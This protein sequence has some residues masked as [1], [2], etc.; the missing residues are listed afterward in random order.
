MNSG[1]TEHEQKKLLQEL[2]PYIDTQEHIQKTGWG[3]YNALFHA[4][5]EYIHHFKR[6]QGLTIDNVMQ[7]QGVLHYAKTLVNAIVDMLKHVRVADEIEPRMI[8]YGKDHAGGTLTREE[9]LTGVPVF[10]SYFQ[11]LLKD[12][13]NKASMA[14]LMNSVNLPM[15]AEM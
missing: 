4:H 6:L 7:S 5:P 9:F 2:S 3:A 10:T 13:E 8:K 1:L 15:A 12:P 11:S 14:K